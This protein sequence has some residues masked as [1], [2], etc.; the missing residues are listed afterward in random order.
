MSRENVGRAKPEPVSPPLPASDYARAIDRFTPL[1]RWISFAVKVLRE[2]GIETHGSC[3]G[4]P[5]HS[6]PEPVVSFHGTN[7]EGYRAVTAA[8]NYGLP[9]RSLNRVWSMVH[10]ELK[11]PTLG[12]PFLAR[13]SP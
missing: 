5:G 12:D 10:G 13:R 9:I 6:Y 7:A 3:Q 8:M 1:D 2:A 4:G 11:G